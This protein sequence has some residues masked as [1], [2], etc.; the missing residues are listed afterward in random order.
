[1]HWLNDSLIEISFF[2]PDMY[3]R[4]LFTLHIFSIS[5]IWLKKLPEEKLAYYGNVLL[6][7][8]W[9]EQGKDN[10]EC[11][12]G[13]KVFSLF[14]LP[15]ESRWNTSRRRAGG[16]CTKGFT[17]QQMQREWSR[18]KKSARII[19]REATSG[20]GSRS[21]Q[22]MT[23]MVNMVV[24]TMMWW[25]G[26]KSAQLFPQKEEYSFRMLWTKRESA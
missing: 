26:R 3:W 20:G 10:K 25:G 23:I 5:K 14:F 13:R 24:W 11:T 22:M 15:D 21:I 1:M 16:S 6:H 7:N 17:W 9:L 2:H 8:K 12:K 18:D 19:W 4:V